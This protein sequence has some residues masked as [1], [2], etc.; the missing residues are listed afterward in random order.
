M[1]PAAGERWLQVRVSQVEQS[2]PVK[3]TDA[4]TWEEIV[5]KAWVLTCLLRCTLKGPELI[6]Y[7]MGGGGAGEWSRTDFILTTLSLL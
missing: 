7:A 4:R 1:E 2:P 5:G 3:E 6:L